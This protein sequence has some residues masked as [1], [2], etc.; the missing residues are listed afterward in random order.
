MK[1]MFLLMPLVA[2]S[3]ASCGKMSVATASAYT[4]GSADSA[5][6]AAE[7]VG[8]VAVENHKLDL[9]TFHDLDSKAY[10]SLLALR[11]ARTAGTQQDVTSANAAFAATIA[12]LNAFKGN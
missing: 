6:I 12:A 4:V 1:R 7:N 10:V 8:K 11:A 5:Y 9:A 2:F 3:L